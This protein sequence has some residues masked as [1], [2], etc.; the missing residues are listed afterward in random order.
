M[1]S[2]RTPTSTTRNDTRRRRG[3]IPSHAQSL[4]RNRPCAIAHA[5][6]YPKLA[7]VWLQ[8]CGCSGGSRWKQ[9]EG[10]SAGRLSGVRENHWLPLGRHARLAQISHTDRRTRIQWTAT[11]M[12][13]MFSSLIGSYLMIALTPLDAPTR[14]FRKSSH[15]RRPTARP[16]ARLAPARSAAA[17]LPG[18]LTGMISRC[19]WVACR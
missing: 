13:L 2:R 11:S 1:I 19:L 5:A 7:L 16:G 6:L 14:S 15:V 9:V 8:V 12:I 3:A 17:A 4:M 18:S 10:E